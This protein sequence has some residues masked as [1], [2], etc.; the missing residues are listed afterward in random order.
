MEGLRIELPGKFDDRFLRHFDRNRLQTCA[1]WEVFKSTAAHS[2]NIGAVPALMQRVS[3]QALPAVNSM[4]ERLVYTHF[5][6]H[7]LG[8]ALSARVRASKAVLIGKKR[9]QSWS[10]PRI[11]NY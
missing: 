2:A 4:V 8:F 6:E 11:P 1:D 9:P 7:F 3:C 5:Q 10:K